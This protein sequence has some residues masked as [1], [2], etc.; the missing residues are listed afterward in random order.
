[1]DYTTVQYVFY[2]LGSF[3]F[4]VGSLIGLAAH[5]GAFDPDL[6]EPQIDL[7]IEDEVRAGVI[8]IDGKAT[9]GLVQHGEMG[10]QDG[11]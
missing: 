9:I 4:I 2:A 8:F 1:M 10:A 7:R 3:C 5:L 11:T 6:P